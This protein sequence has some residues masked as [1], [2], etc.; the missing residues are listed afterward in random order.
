[1]DVAVII[2]DTFGRAWRVGQ[3]DVAIG[4][5]GLSPFTDYRGSTDSQGRELVAT[6]ICVADEI[7]GAAELVMGKATGIC[8]AI[9]RGVAWEPTRAAATEIARAPS[10]DF[11]R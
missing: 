2:T 9:V 5:A 10:D 3:T 8:V 4:V 7:A 11:F 1:V 6:R